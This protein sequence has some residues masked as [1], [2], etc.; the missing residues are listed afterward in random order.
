MA[1][2][3]APS[4]ARTKGALGLGS[5]G[6]TEDAAWRRV[7]ASETP[8]TVAGR[9]TYCSLR[10]PAKLRPLARDDRQL[11][12]RR[13]ERLRVGLRLADAHVQRDL[14]DGRHLHDRRDAELVLEVPAE[15]GLV[16]GLQA[17]HVAVAGAVRLLASLPCPYF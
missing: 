17:R 6:A 8:P 13:V 5:P 2:S 10:S 3:R 16:G 15:L 12:H 11:V 4:Q 1:R 7:I 9:A 14:G